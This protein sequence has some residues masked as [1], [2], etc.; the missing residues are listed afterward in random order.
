MTV[1]LQSSTTITYNQSNVE[2]PM[3]ESEKPAKN[4]KQD[5]PV[6]VTGSAPFGALRGL[7]FTWTLTSISLIGDPGENRRE[8]YV[9]LGH[10]GVQIGVSV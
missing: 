10:S 2:E 6:T 1:T 4:V 3:S 9:G 5:A 7:Y 8:R